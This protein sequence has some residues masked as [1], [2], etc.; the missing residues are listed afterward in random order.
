MS[1]LAELAKRY[2]SMIMHV[3]D[4]AADSYVVWDNGMLYRYAAGGAVDSNT[5]GVIIKS[6]PADERLV[7]LPFVM[8]SDTASDVPVSAV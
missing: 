6:P 4:E 7:V 2:E 1:A 3:S 5:K 8:G